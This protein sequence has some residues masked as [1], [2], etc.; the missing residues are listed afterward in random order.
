[1]SDH[2][3]EAHSHG[4][5][6]SYLVGFIWSVILT[7][8]PFWMVMTEAFD[9]GPTYITIVLLAIVQIFVHLKYF[10]HLDFSEQG[11]LDTYSFIF[12]AVIIVMVVA[13][14][15]WIIYASNAMMM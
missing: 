4:S 14:S 5:V 11:K 3:S 6:K 2:S 10:L 12:S 1:M 8:I 13:L 9:K 7:G 15:V